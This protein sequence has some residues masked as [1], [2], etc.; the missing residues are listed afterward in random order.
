MIFFFLNMTYDNIILEEI[1]VNVNVLQI[2]RAQVRVHF[3]FE[4]FECSL[5]YI[6]NFTE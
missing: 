1:S 2:I 6:F 4:L 3:K 5:F